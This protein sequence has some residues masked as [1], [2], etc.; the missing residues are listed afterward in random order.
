[1]V[2]EQLRRIPFGDT[3]S[4]AELAAEVGNPRACRAVGLANGRNPVS[5]IVPCH[6]VIA[7]DGSLGGYG[8]GLDR[9]QLLLRH[10]QSVLAGAGAA[11]AG[12]PAGAS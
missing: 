8:G 3:W 10:E 9:K 2:W 12:A 7:S 4:Y 5:I 1:R 11:A 6:R